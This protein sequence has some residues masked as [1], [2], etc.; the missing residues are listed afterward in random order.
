MAMAAQNG[1]Y[2]NHH[3]IVGFKIVNLMLCEIYFN[4]KMI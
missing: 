2:T 3:W 4:Y 1:E